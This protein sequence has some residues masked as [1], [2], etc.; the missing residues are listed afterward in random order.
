MQLQNRTHFT[1]NFLQ[2]HVLL[3]QLLQPQIIV[4]STHQISTFSGSNEELFIL[5]PKDSGCNWITEKSQVFV[6]QKVL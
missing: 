4:H 5:N 1:D 2:L 6:T 3:L